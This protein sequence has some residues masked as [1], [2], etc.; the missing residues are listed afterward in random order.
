MAQVE[1]RLPVFSECSESCGKCS[2][3]EIFLA[4]VRVLGGRQLKR[5]YNP[6]VLETGY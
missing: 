6:I 2:Q 1:I 5:D 4:E 3:G